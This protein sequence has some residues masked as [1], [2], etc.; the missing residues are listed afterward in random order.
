MQTLKTNVMVIAPSNFRFL[1]SLSINIIF[2]PR[3]GKAIILSIYSGNQNKFLLKQK[4]FVSGKGNGLK[5]GSTTVCNSDRPVISIEYQINNHPRWFRLIRATRKMKKG[6]L[7]TYE[8]YHV[9]SCVL[10]VY[11]STSTLNNNTHI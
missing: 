1:Q 5:K 11:T 4:K 3:C 8:M 10:H 2:Y 9:F 7:L 6:V